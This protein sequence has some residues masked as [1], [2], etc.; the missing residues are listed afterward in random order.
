VREEGVAK[1]SFICVYLSHHRD[2]SRVI[3]DCLGLA[4]VVGGFV[5]GVW[6]QRSAC[7]WPEDLS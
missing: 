2:T 1:K 6:A 5:G 3:H 4:I 7:C